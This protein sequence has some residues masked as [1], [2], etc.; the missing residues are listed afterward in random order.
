[1][2]KIDI[3]NNSS[4]TTVESAIILTLNKSQCKSEADH[5]IWV[6]LIFSFLGS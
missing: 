4:T 3:F 2:E 6:S 5:L 1:M